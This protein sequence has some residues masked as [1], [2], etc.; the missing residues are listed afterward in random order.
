MMTVQLIDVKAITPNPY[1]PRQVMD[2]VTIRE[3][4]AS[5]QEHGLLQPPQVRALNGRYQLAFGHRR[6]AAWKIAKPGEPF[7]C[8]IAEL[9]DRQMFDRAI[10]E[11]DD[12]EP[13]NPVE[14]ARALHRYIDEFHVTQ[15]EAGKRFKLGTQGAVSN[16]LRLLKLPGSI[17]QMVSNGELAER[18]AR[19]L[20]AAAQI[21]PAKKLEHIAKAFSKTSGEEKQSFIAEELA[22][23]FDDFGCSLDNVEW[24]MDWPETPVPVNHKGG[25]KHD[26]TELIACAGCPF[27]TKIAYQ[28]WCARPECYDLKKGLWDCD[29]LKIVAEKLGL[30]VATI[31]QANSDGFHIL[32]DGTRYEQESMAQRL[33]RGGDEL[34]LWLVESHPDK[35]QYYG[36]SV[37]GFTGIALGTSDKVA[38]DRY[39]KSFEKGSDA[40]KPGTVLSPEQFKKREEAGRAARRAERASELKAKHDVS[41]LIT[42]AA[43]EI[44]DRLTISGGVVEMLLEEI[45]YH[46][47]DFELLVAWQNDLE[48][49]VDNIKGAE[50]EELLR[51]QIAFR[52]ICGKCCHHDAR[53]KPSYDWEFTEQRL[54]ALARSNSS[55]GAGFDVKLP[56]GWNKSPIH[57]TGYNCHHCGAFASSEKLT[58]RDQAE[59]W[60]IAMKDKAIADVR[61][62]ACA[63]DKG[64]YWVQ[65]IPAPAKKGKKK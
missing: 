34:Q 37:F 39:L 2:D 27:N 51:Q 63:T 23:A 49:K 10:V 62:P 4:A 47:Y 59:G 9:D 28:T 36:K 60:A 46:I 19:Q 50:R 33:L 29:K 25:A 61:C 64:G 31:E 35:N 26:V 41:W 53:N 17:Q 30:Q 57:K 32:F 18:E 6:L 16:V 48:E 15:L 20:V 3:L 8:E 11:N 65:P 5:I 24:K 21:V 7:P 1:Q 13:L 52:L 45:S 40:K 14:R 38:C 56:T 43:R 12:R 22:N 54:L 55:W 44:G 58:K 42:N